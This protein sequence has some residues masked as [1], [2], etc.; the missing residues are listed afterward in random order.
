[1][2]LLFILIAFFQLIE[3]RKCKVTNDIQESEIEASN[4]T[5]PSSTE[6]RTITFIQPSK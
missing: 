6:Q 1:M 2:C 3:K 5:D 4:H